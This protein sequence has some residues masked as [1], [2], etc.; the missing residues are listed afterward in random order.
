MTLSSLQKDAQQGQDWCWP[1]IP[2]KGWKEFRILPPQDSFL[3]TFGDLV[4][5]QYAPHCQRYRRFSQFKARFSDG[6]WT[7][8]LLPHRP[9]IQSAEYNKF[10]GGILRE[11]EP[12][13]C[14][15]EPY[16][17]EVLSLL[18]T[19]SS[20][21]YHLDVHQYRVYAT[22]EAK[23]ISVP[24]G[25]HRDGQQCVVIL[26]FRR[27]RITGAE[28]T[29]HDP[30]T[31]EPFH[32]TVIGENAGVALDDEKMLHDASDIIAVGAERGHRDYVVLNINEWGKR[33]YGEAFERR[34]INPLE[35]V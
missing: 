35:P 8:D 3:S 21:E 24:E 22:G 34:A 12:L 9:F 13:K 14:D 1:A 19:D 10:S 16:L 2:K 15:A 4:F 32:R 18:Q 5:D 20:R 23:G 6:F 28:M 33:R 27:H 17:D 26:V 30:L 11:F 31:L 29:L 25:P 7:F